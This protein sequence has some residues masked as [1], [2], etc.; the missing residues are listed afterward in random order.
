MGKPFVF[1]ESLTH[2]ILELLGL[3]EKDGN[4][5]Y[6]RNIKTLTLRLDQKD[7]EVV[8]A[9]VEEL[10]YLDNGTYTIIRYSV[11]IIDDIDKCKLPALKD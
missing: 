5:F 9:D 2:K 8:R 10:K 3:T 7:S 1:E 6:K 4:G 11:P